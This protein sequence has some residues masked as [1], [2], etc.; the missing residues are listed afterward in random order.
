MTQQT[1]TI[2]DLLAPHTDMIG[3]QPLTAGVSVVSVTTA[4]GST[5]TSTTRHAADTGVVSQWTMNDGDLTTP[6]FGATVEEKLNGTV[7][8]LTAIIAGGKE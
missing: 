4:A 8:A 1:V 6:Q 2:G 3:D 7:D 5:I